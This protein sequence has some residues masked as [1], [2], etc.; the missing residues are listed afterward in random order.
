MTYKNLLQEVNEAETTDFCRGDSI[1]AELKKQTNQLNES[2]EEVEYDSLPSFVRLY[3]DYIIDREEKLGVYQK[4]KTAIEGANK[5]HV[6]F[7][8]KRLLEI[9]KSKLTLPEEL[10]LRK[11]NQIIY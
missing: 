8:L 6:V 11:D 10:K 7:S 9:E 1:I 5:V 4:I 3:Y 2:D